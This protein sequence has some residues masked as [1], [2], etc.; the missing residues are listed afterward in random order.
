LYATT[1]RVVSFLS[2]AAFGAA[3][4]LG[5]LVMGDGAQTQHWGI[6]GIVLILAAGLALMIP[7]RPAAEQ[8][9]FE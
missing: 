5:H 7:V 2:P 3:I 1:G 8:A 6:L 9:S 4:A